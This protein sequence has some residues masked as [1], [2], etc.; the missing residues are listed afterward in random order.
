M[1]VDRREFLTGTAGFLVT[2]ALPSGPTR[3]LG[4]ADVV[5]LRE[6]VIHLYKLGDEH[7]A[8]SVYPLTVRT[9]HKLRQL[10][11][12]ASEDQATGLARR[13]SAGR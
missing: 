6:S 5:E 2:A 1:N 12:H 9:L 4:N 8:G 13:N 7:G 10:I 11:E 3:R